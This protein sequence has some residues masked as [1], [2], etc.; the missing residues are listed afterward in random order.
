MDPEPAWYLVVLALGLLLGAALL[1]AQVAALCRLPRVTAYLLVGMLLGPYVLGTVPASWPAAVGAP[2]AF[3]AGLHTFAVSLEK[4][5]PLADLAMALV[6][7]NI[8]CHFTLVHFRKT[9]RRALHLSAGELGMTF[10]CVAGGLVIFGVSW[11]AALLLGSLALAT[12]PATTVLVLKENQS[13]GPITEY[14]T[15]LVVLNNLAA[16]VV[17]ELLFVGLRA[18]SGSGDRSAALE[19][20][21]LAGDLSLAGG[22][23]LAAGLGASYACGLLD[24]SQWLVLLVAVVAVV[25]GLSHAMEIPYLLAFLVMGATVANASDR[26][27]E[28][29]EELDR[30]TGLLC[31]VFFGV[32]GASMDPVALV[33]AGT[34]GAAYI[35]FRTFGKCAGISVAARTHH[36][37]PQVRRWL[38]P[39]L[40]CQAGAAIAL[41]SVAMRYDPALGQR[42]KEIILGTVVFFEIVGPL[43]IRLGVMRSG[44]VPLEKAIQH[45]STTPGEEL[46][47]MLNRLLTALG[48]DPF[49]G[50][51]LDDV[52]VSQLMRAHAKGV[53]PA[54]TFDELVDFIEASHDN[55]FPVVNDENVMMG[56]IRYTDVRDALFYPRLGRLVCAA[57]LA[58]PSPPRLHADDPVTR[59]WELFLHSQDDSWPVVTRE[60][61]YKLMGMVRRKDLLRLFRRGSARSA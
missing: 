24:R 5:E 42:L 57:D 61:P 59:A 23:G 29:V 3:A 16:V 52:T 11:Q 51:P 53:S 46:R 20:A 39:T 6:L 55:T 10:V 1:G 47:N 26:T 54:A 40:L 13:E 18:V 44:E 2:A 35:V 49:A 4:L 28:I 19:L 37:G 33:H 22:V 56:V 14:A 21:D 25:L 41:T 58:V 9:F 27:D 12:A 48:R 50:R 8:G 45:R 7:F 34:V 43:C 17:F 32:H 31:V 38:G 30:L 15:A 60:E 36:D